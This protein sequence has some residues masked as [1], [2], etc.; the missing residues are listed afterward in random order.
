MQ[1][2][3]ISPVIQDTQRSS[4]HFKHE[5][6]IPSGNPVKR[7]LVMGCMGLGGGW[8]NLAVT[9]ADEN[10]ARQTI[11]TAIQNGIT[12]FD[13]ADIYTFGK[14]EEAFGRVLADSP[15]LRNEIHLQSKTGICLRAGENGETHY[16]LSRDY[17]VNQVLAILKR[18]RTDYLDTLL[19]HR[20]DPLMRAD[21]VAQAF[22]WLHTRGLVRFFGVSNMHLKHIRYLSG[23]SHFPITIN[24]LQLS[25]GHRLL[26]ESD[27]SV[28]Q[29]G[30]SPSASTDGLLAYCHDQGVTLQAWGPLDQGLYL[31]RDK[32]SDQNLPVFEKIQQLANRHN[33]SPEAILLAWLFALP[34]RVVPIIGTT[35]PER[36]AACA[37]SIGVEL[38]RQEWYDLWIAARGKAL[39]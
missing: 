31:N 34:A 36:I 3:L 27:I 39:P 12:T 23:Q 21:E 26:I 8:N 37:Q 22:E 5:R 9:A 11:E 19:L 7:E 15:G 16:N 4:Y 25:L 33:A 38:T 1:R 28:N 14:A 20:P 6:M 35:R 2:M 32:A 17:I 13:H 30:V 18:L 24:Q 10:L 29:S